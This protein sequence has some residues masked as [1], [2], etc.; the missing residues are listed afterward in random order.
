MKKSDIA[1]II[2]IASFSIV[3]AFFVARGLFGDVYEGSATVK[4]IDRIDSSIVPP[5]PEIFNKN[6]INP[7]IQ[8]VVNGTQ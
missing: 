6:A 5:D 7:S 2:F 3:I 8:V 1:M 4:T